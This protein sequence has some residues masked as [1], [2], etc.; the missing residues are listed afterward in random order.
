M[1]QVM[2][3]HGD[4][5]EQPS[6]NLTYEDILAML[7]VSGEVI[8]TV[9]SESVDTIKLGLKN[10]KAKQNAYLKNRNLPTDD[11]T[12]EFLVSPSKEKDSVDMT[13]LLKTKGLSCIS[14][15]LVPSSTYSI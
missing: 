10:K 7:A 12:L 14:K 4:Y 11:S 9:T 8:L 15:V 3:E 5:V 13:I 2:N 1:T 6:E